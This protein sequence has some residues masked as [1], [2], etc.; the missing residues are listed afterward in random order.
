MK[1]QLVQIFVG[2]PLANYLAGRI[3]RARQEQ[4]AQ[5]A[6]KEEPQAGEAPTGASDG[7]VVLEGGKDVEAGAK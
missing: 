7:L 4:E 6:L 3:L 1:T 5:L 2:Q